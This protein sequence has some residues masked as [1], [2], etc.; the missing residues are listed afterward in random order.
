MKGFAHR[1]RLLGAP[2]AQRRG[3]LAFSIAAA[4]F[5]TL[6]FAGEEPADGGA[7]ATATEEAAPPASVDEGYSVLE[8]G[9]LDD[10]LSIFNA[11]L[12]DDAD[13]LQALLGR[14]LIFAEQQ[15]HEEAFSS[16]DAIVRRFPDHAFAWNG[17]GLAAFNMENFDAALVSFER[18]TADQPVNGFF[19]ESIAWT[20]MC[21][22]EF[23][24]AAESA[25]TAS[26]M[27]NREGQ[28]S[29]YPLLIA[30]FAY[31][32]TGDAANA[33]RTLRY[34][35]GNVRSR[36]WPLPVLQYVSGRIG[37]NELIGSV[38][39]T[40]EETEAHTYI[41]L[42]LRQSGDHREA[43]RHLDWVRHRGDPR[44][45]EYTLAR[46]LGEPAGMARAGQTSML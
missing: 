27:Y 15:R 8:R 33:A 19:Y 26:L 30:Y 43:A 21:R 6:S 24:D 22:G 32:E 31:R 29:L 17:R 38:T 42:V 45:F 13:N 35:E 16:Y 18:A 10:A 28:M 39:N 40:A 41:G 4:V 3:L 36:A 20:Q 2:A 23:D 25:K 9:M 44:V 34:A 12:S 14:A 7:P 5:L 1:L 11:V 37:P 46:S